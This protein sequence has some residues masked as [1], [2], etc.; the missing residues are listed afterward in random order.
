M[1]RAIGDFAFRRKGLVLLAT[2]VL[3][4]A[5][6][7]SLLVGGKLTGA[8]I[9]G[10]E[11]TAADRLIESVLGRSSDTT[12]VFLFRSKTLAPDSPEFTTTMNA[13]LAAV[14]E[15]PAV[16]KVET[17]S[18]V[19][20]RLAAYALVTL[21][22]DLQQALANYPRVRELVRSDAL[23]ITATG[24]L[25]FQT[26]LNLQLEKDLLLAELVSLPLALIVLLLVFRTA[27][28]AILPVAVG[29]VAV[30]GGIAAVL[31]LSHVT[32]ISQYT[33]NVCSLIGLGVAIDY[34]LFTVSRYREELAAG[35]DYREALVRAVDHA[36]RVVAFSALAVCSGLA[37]L[38]FFKGS[39]LM[40]MGLG[41]ALVVALAA[42]CALTT[43]PALL[44]LLGPRIHSLKL[45]LPAFAVKSGF[46]HRLALGVMRRPVLVLVPTLMVLLALASPFTRLR[47]AASDVRMLPAE[48]EAARGF[49][50]LTQLFPDEAA[51]HFN[52]AVRFASGEPFT[53]ERIGALHD[54][55]KRLSTLPG[56]TRVLSPVFGDPRLSRETYQAL[57][58]NPPP[59]Q[60]PLIEGAKRAFSKGSVVFLQG[61]SSAAPD[62]VEARDVVEAIRS[63]RMVGDGVLLVGGE[64]AS[65]VDNTDFIVRR[66]PRAVAFVVS[67]TLLVLFL[68]LGSVLLPIKAVLMNFLSIGGSFGALVLLF[69][70]SHGLEPALPVL[71]F[72]VLFGLSMDYEVLILTRMREAWERTGDNEHAVGEGLEKTAGLVT[73]AAS[74]MVAVFIAFG[75]A[76][77]VLIQA[78]G[79]GMAIAVALDATLVRV[80]LVPATMRLFGKANWWGPKWLKRF[81]PGRPRTGPRSL[82]SRA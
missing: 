44:A 9:T 66:T 49:Q 43:L 70:K 10:L 57:F 6:V 82:L 11:S 27:V 59:A 28:A 77:V 40:T 60:A 8:T 71:L 47:L 80:L 7:A 25:P 72:C 22:G 45:P 41:G 23:E 46:W 34:S 58:S 63:E 19:D 32:D 42:L 5:S 30:L 54:L 65:D 73:S 38:L 39:Y 68:L 20:A 53:P 29:G 1:F 37:G 13:A 64:T 31:A 16:S 33:I 35:H 81:P 79:V 36:G 62:S 51:T 48:L 14:R 12:S 4:L 69:Q 2:A 26:D 24:Q 52:V 50:L 21:A 76:K 18:D 67:A 74:I 55:S 15:D 61:I 56:V 78:V 75:L 3:L 17:L